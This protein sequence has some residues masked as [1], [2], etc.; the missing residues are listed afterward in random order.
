MN[1]DCN[2]FDF[3]AFDFND[4]DF[5]GLDFSMS[6]FR[7][8]YLRFIAQHKGCPA[9]RRMTPRSRRKRAAKQSAGR[10]QGIRA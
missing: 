5:N 9:R 4:S 8:N 1:L 7:F 6:R 2:G 10:A 3:D